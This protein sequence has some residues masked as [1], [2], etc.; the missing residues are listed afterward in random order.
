MKKT[1][2]VGFQ[3]SLAHQHRFHHFQRQ[4]HLSVRHFLHYFSLL[5]VI[6]TF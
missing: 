4:V 6:Y 3:V 2:Q 1:T 5:N